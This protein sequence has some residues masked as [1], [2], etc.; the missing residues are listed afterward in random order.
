MRL[1]TS[2]NNFDLSDV[3]PAVDSVDSILEI[4][5]EVLVENSPDPGNTRIERLARWAIA[6]LDPTVSFEVVGAFAVC[7]TSSTMVSRI[8][9]RVAVQRPGSGAGWVEYTPAQCREVATALLGAAIAAEES[10]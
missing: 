9:E 6:N 5:G 2:G 4:A 7:R 1:G 3:E 10:A 8:G